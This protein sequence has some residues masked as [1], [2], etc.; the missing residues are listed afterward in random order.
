MH[1]GLICPS[2]PQLPHFICELCQVRGI[3]N[4]E[5]QTRAKDL[6][7]LLIERMRLIDSLS[8]WQ[9]STLK[10]YGPYLGFLERFEDYYGARVLRPTVLVRPPNS[11]GI[12]LVW[13]QQLY[14]LRRYQGDRI[15]FNTIRM[16]RSAASLYY[17]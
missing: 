12:A 17:T 13:A 1:N 8:W 2:G 10:T 14:S 16:L 5:L 7:L 6:E 11:P 15:K 9:N 3:I 4:R